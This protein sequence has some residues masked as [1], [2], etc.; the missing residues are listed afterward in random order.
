[1]QLGHNFAHGTT[2]HLFWN[3]Q[4]CDVTALSKSKEKIEFFK[5]F[6][7]KAHKSFVKSILAHMGRS[8]AGIVTPLSERWRRWCPDSDPGVQSW[9]E[10]VLETRA[11]WILSVCIYGYMIRVKA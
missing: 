3:V 4:I 5:S 11:V 2:D 7:L 10:T 6:Q 1:M 9:Q 8:V